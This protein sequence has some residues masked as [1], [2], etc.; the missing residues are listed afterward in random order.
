MTS[1]HDFV[2]EQQRGAAYG[3]TRNQAVATAIE[4]P[5][6]VALLATESASAEMGIYHWYYPF[7]SVAILA[8]ADRFQR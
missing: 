1:F 2:G 6:E 3:C 7:S 5:E 4:E 8:N